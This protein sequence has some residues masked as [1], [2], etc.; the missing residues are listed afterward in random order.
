[1]FNK[2]RAN[3]AQD[4]TASVPIRKFPTRLHL[5]CGVCGHQGVASIFLNQVDKLKCRA[6]GSR[7]V[8]VVSRDQSSRSWARRR[9]G[10]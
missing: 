4:Q 10:R 3:S 8:V 6:C 2:P 5:I 7:D 1:V 9:M